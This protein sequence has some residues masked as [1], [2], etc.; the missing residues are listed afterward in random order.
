MIIQ[1]QQSYVCNGHCNSVLLNEKVYSKHIHM[2]NI[3]FHD[4]FIYLI[5]IT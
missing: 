2:Q 4:L 1:I 3:A 5:D